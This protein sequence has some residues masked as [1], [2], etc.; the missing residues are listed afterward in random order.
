MC[1]LSEMHQSTLPQPF[2]T[3]LLSWRPCTHVGSLAWD[4][5]AGLGEW[6]VTGWVQEHAEPTAHLWKEEIWL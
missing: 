3:A 2:P 5:G 4:D 1:G 6:A